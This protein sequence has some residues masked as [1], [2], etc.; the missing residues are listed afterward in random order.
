[1]LS[2]LYIKD[3]AIVDELEIEFPAGFIVITG[4]TGAGKSILVGALGLLCGE[5]GQSDLVRASASK[6]ILE[7]DFHYQANDDVRQ[8]LNANGIDSQGDLLIIRREINNRGGSRAF[9]NDTPVN[10]NVLNQITTLLVDLHGQHQHQRLIY[11]ENHIIYLDDFGLLQQITDS[12]RNAYKDYKQEEK[13]L[14][15]F[16]KRKKANIEKHDLYMFQVSELSKAD[17]QENELESL[18]Q[19]R[20]ILENNEALFETTHHAG[21]ILY[22]DEN[23]VSN[24]M[25]EVIRKLR[26]MAGIDPS[27]E[28]LI[29]NLETAQIAVEEIG[30]QCVTYSAN[31]E[32][33]PQRL[34]EIQKREAELLWLIKK[35][36]VHHITELIH[37]LEDMKLQLTELDHSD[38]KIKEIEKSLEQKQL[39]LQELALQLSSKRALV[40]KNFE[41]ELETILDSI[42]L[43][44]ARFEVKITWQESD[45]GLV[46]VNDKKYDL[47]ENGLDRIE[48]HVGLNIGEPARPLHKVASGGEVSRIMLAIKTLLAATDQLDTLIFDEIDSGISGRFAQI[49]GRKMREIAD[50]HQLIVITH[51][52]QIAAQGR[53]HFVVAKE[54]MN[55]R[56]KV[57]VNQ[58][59]NDDRVADIARLLGGEHITPEAMANAR[60]LLNGAL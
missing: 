41:K 18:I 20:K 43:P 16:L 48:F 31:L 58:L 33:N 54:E 49:V 39:Y 25:S 5:K 13:R 12:V 59:Q 38:E 17:L 26:A 60:G 53:T 24:N 42:G 9:I 44:K 36:Q 40:S 22:A 47:S 55:G 4:E 56:T 35:Y 11:P 51:L 15:E 45:K 2:R 30:R 50:H 34:E 3:F 10:I 6:A 14:N 52:P 29:T 46:S 57:S 19:E 32:F 37:H 21:T 23:S 1:M 27:F 7:A 8:I 28:E